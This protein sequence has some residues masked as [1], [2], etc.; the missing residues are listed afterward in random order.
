MV[1][2]KGSKVCEMI[3]ASKNRSIEAIMAFFL[4]YYLDV[5]VN[6]NRLDNYH[7]NVGHQ[8]ILTV[9]YINWCLYKTRTRGQYLASRYCL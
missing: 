5:F 1:W 4:F 9:H 2:G 7:N 6:N 3:F 8:I